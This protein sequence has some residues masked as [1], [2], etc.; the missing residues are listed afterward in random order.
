MASLLRANWENEAGPS[1]PST[2]LEYYFFSDKSHLID[3]EARHQLKLLTRRMLMSVDVSDVESKYKYNDQ[4]IFTEHTR[5]IGPLL[6]KHIF[7][8]II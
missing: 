2:L 7:I 6:A 1:R 4:Q 5:S 8:M 3:R